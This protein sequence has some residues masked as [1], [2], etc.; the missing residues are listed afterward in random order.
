VQDLLGWGALVLIAV[1]AVESALG[2]RAWARTD[3]GP[4]TSDEEV[5]A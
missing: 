5:L 1:Y 4:V 3:A 2:W